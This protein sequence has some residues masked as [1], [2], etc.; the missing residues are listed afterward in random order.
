MKP[1]A[2]LR[3]HLEDEIITG[4]LAP[5]T[6]LDEVS[7]AKKFGFSRTPIREALFQLEAI[8]LVDI[9]P[10]RGAIVSAPDLQRLIEMFETM[11]EFEA[12]CA[13]LASRRVT[14]DDEEALL[15][16]HR[17]CIAAAAAGDHETYYD[18]N[19]A[20]HAA[21][22]RASHNSFL[23]EQS[24]TLHRRLTSFR[25]AQLHARNR[26]AQS[27]QEHESI[28]QAI[29]AGDGDLAAQ[30]IRDHIVIQSERFADVVA[31]LTAH[32]ST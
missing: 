15:T 31:S 1:T 3:Q 18:E 28:V 4:K 9:R 14:S 16:A 13:R 19:A 20:F 26:I 11:A 29:L 21:I 7:L 6:R 25:R 17:A 5:G 22:Y 23:A 8:G 30:R 32:P 12:S 24:R 10:R 27:L 2:K